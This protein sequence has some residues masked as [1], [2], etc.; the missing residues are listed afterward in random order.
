LQCAQ[1]IGTPQAAGGLGVKPMVIIFPRFVDDIFK[2]TSS[3]SK[4]DPTQ[5]LV[6][7][8][9]KSTI[10]SPSWGGKSSSCKAASADQPGCHRPSSPHRDR[11]R[12]APGRAAIG[13]QARPRSWRQV[14][15]PKLEGH[16]RQDAPARPRTFDVAHEIADDFDLMGVVGRDFNVSELIL[17]QE[18]QF[19]TIEPVGPEIVTE[20]RFVRDASDVNVEVLGNERANFADRQALLTR[21][22]LRDAQAAEDHDKPPRIT[23]RQR[24]DQAIGSTL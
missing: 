13:T 8:C 19:Q 14:R 12:R 16:R 2:T 24:F 5:K 20:V 15:R 21:C 10:A 1:W 17:D 7:C 23:E 18:Q 9:S 22:W 6:E 4:C 3:R 11:R